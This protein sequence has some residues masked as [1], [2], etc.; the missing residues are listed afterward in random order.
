MNRIYIVLVVVLALASCKQEGCRDMDAVNFDPAVDEDDGSCLFEGK[1]V[2][3]YDEDVTFPLLADGAEVL[4]FYVDDAVIGTH[5][6]SEFWESAPGCGEEGSLSM[7]K[8]LGDEPYATC[9]YEVIDQDGFIR[10]TG[11][12]GFSK[13]ECVS[14]ELE[15]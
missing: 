4:T 15:E 11:E 8:Y 14:F 6:A 12:F 5:I 3:W 9:L 10:W 2:F 13:G 7:T 1:V